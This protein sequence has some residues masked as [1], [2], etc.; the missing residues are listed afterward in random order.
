MSRLST[1]NSTR[2]STE[3]GRRGGAAAG[4][5][6]VELLVALVVATLV[7]AAAVAVTFANRRVVSMD[8]ARTSLNQNL[9]TGLSI[10]GDDVQVSGER[11]PSRSDAYLPP[12]EVQGGTVLILRRNLLDVVLPVCKDIKAGSNADAVF[13]GLKHN[14]S[15][16]S[17]CT[18][19]G[20]NNDPNWPDNLGAWRDYRLTHGNAVP[21]FIIDPITK[22]H[23]FFTY[24]AED[25]SNFHIHRASGKWV[26]DYSVNNKPQVY[27]LQQ[28]RFQ[29]VN[30][31]LEL[32][33][34]GDTASPQR[35]IPHVT[36]FQVRA[37]LDDGTVRTDFPQAG[38]SFASLKYVRVTINGTAVQGRQSVDR[39]I[40]AEFFP[41]NVLSQ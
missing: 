6:L 36:D 10:I 34:D 13:V 7:I 30:D 4:L 33:L 28:R 9:R 26:W 22:D 25:N 2:P 39:E 29:R 18:I 31:F 38:D 15:G 41:R 12:I 27:V 11:L 14:N 5:T 35:L 40:S 16:N 21:A 8:Q 32:F 24:D 37:V 20:Y 23:E 19:D 3:P 1:P 17:N